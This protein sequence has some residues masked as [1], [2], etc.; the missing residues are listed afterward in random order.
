MMK[1][2]IFRS[3]GGPHA[4]FI[5]KMAR[6]GGILRRVWYRL[7]PYHRAVLAI[8]KRQLSSEGCRKVIA[9]TQQG[10]RETAQYYRVPEEKVAVIYNGV[11]ALRFNPGRRSKEG[12]QI[13]S[14]LS[15]PADDQVVLF[16]GTGF[17]RKGLD[18]LLHLWSEN[19]FEGVH[20]IVVG[21]DSKLAHY[22]ERWKRPDI[23][24]VG[25]RTNVEDYYA[26][27]DLLVLPSIQE[28]FG[29]VVLEALASGLPI[30]TI[31]GVGVTD[32]M[33]GDLRM[34]IL[35][36]PDDPAELRERILWLLDRSSWGSLSIAAR[37]FAEKYSWARYLSE[38]EKE[39]F[40]VARC[41]HE[42][43]AS[44]KRDLDLQNPIGLTKKR[45]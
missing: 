14:G 12:K 20:L 25:A 19:G 44:S 8:E 37:T 23:F 36:D 43:P 30:I 3:G 21:D 40:E 18:R 42:S 32:E 22:R 7:S 5:E 35:V 29:N 34:G 9:V 28:A 6:S 31:P 17:R 11:D 15:I 10:K 13:R 45:L 16:V 24:F 41:I 27:G 39:V 4:A 2:D 26:A 1:Q 38:F 33:E